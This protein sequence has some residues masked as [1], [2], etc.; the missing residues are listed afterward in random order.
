MQA[1][2]P[3]TNYSQ[4]QSEDGAFAE[5][6]MQKDGQSARIPEG[7]SYTDAATFG[8]GVITVGQG[9]YQSLGLPLPPKKAEEKF[10]ILIYGGSSATGTLA[11]QYAKL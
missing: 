4:K 6:I 2:C 10:P 3:S 11:I 9:L 7:M 5:Y 1:C 8:V